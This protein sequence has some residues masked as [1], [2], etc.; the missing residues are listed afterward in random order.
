MSDGI[1][2]PSVD[3]S[4]SACAAKLSG[5]PSPWT[6]GHSARNTRAVR[7][8][9]TEN[10]SPVT[11]VVSWARNTTNGATLSGG[12]YVSRNV[13]KPSSS[14]S[15]AVMRVNAAGMTELTLIPEYRPSAASAR[16]SP[17]MPALLE[18]YGLVNGVPNTDADD[19]LT[20][21]PA[22]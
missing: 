10:V 8:A 2:Q 16:V 7:S 12:K 9:P 19:M 15:C 14:G 11:V 13:R 3:M 18:T 6:P 20:I 4:A 17:K 22:P 1:S 21:R 5:V